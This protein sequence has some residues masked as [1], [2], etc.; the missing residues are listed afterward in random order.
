MHLRALL[1][2][3]VTL[4]L[5]LGVS[6]VRAGDA[7]D[8]ETAGAQRLTV[9]VGD[10]LA[11]DPPTLTVTAG[12]PVILTIR[13]IGNTD[14]DWTITGLPARDIKSAVQAGHGHPRTGEIVGHPKPK[15]EVTIRF[16]PT[17]PGT[18]EFYCSVPGHRQAG[19]QGLLQVTEP[20]TAQPASG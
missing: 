3:V 7:A 2:V 14:H 6:C 9:T 4:P 15:G 8:E 10:S 13:N 12:K 5:I 20:T 19:M 17:Q 16:T 1:L 11:F 18:Y